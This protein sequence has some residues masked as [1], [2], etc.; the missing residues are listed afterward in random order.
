MPKKDKT[1]ENNVAKRGIA[2]KG[3]PDPNRARPKAGI[4]E[5]EKVVVKSKH[6]KLGDRKGLSKD[7]VSAKT[8]AKKR[9]KKAEREKKKR[10]KKIKKK[11]KVMFINPNEK[12]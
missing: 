6:E 5:E 1:A 10:K 12:D 11:Q 8:K 3:A 7:E 4:K 9:D 2:L